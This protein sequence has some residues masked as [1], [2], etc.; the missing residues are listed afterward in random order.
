MD[1]HSPIDPRVLEA[2]RQAQEAAKRQQ[3]FDAIKIR[4]AQ[5]LWQRVHK[6]RS[7]YLR[8]RAAQAAAVSDGAHYL[9]LRDVDGHAAASVWIRSRQN[10]IRQVTKKSERNI[11]VGLY[12]IAAAVGENSGPIDALRQQ[13]EIAK[14]HL[15]ILQALVGRH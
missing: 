1:T 11:A 8:N 2:Q 4:Y 5:A 10:A 7:L 3:R 6:N 13:Q 14:A 9:A 15:Q 12:G